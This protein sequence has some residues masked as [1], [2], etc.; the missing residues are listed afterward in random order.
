V[1]NGLHQFS[2]DTLPK[3]DDGK[4]ALAFV[5]HVRRA[6]RDCTDRPGEPKP[7]VVT[8]TVSVTPV[9]QSN[10]DCDEARVQIKVKSDTPVHQTKPY[11]FGLR[12][13]G[14]LVFSEHSPNDVNQTTLMDGD[15]N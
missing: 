6:A 3:L 15:T 11:S 1:A 2:L 14:V 13:N 7:R 4:A 8:L 9:M 12:A 10:G 5:E